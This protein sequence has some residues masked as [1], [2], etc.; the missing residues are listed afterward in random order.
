ML[1]DSWDTHF[2]TE[3]GMQEVYCGVPLE[4][5]VSKNEGSRI[6]HREMMNCVSIATKVSAAPGG[7]LTC[8]FQVVL[9]WGKWF[10]LFPNRSI[11]RMWPAYR[12]GT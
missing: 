5:K 12:K 1:P 2:E 9:L 6:E 8:S 3:I 4:K 7:V 11:N 10:P